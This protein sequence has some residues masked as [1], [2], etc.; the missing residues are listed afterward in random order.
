[1]P[2][3]STAKTWAPKSLQHVGAQQGHHRADEEGGGGDDRYGVQPGPL[4]QGEDGGPAHLGRPTDRPTNGEQQVA[5][6][7][8]EVV[9]TQND[10]HDAAAEAFEQVVERAPLT[11]RRAAAPRWHGRPGPVAA[12]SPRER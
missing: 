1:M 2:I 5:V 6:E 12:G 9:E 11:D 10:A 4:G 3:R 7:Y 8:V